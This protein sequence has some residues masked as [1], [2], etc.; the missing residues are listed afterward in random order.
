MNKMSKLMQAAI[1]EAF[2]QPLVL[3]EVPIPAP[4][5]GQVLIQVKASGV[6]HTDV[7]A[8]DGDWPVA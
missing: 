7:H 3:K 2:G 6:C 8:A 5:E 4:R 1:V